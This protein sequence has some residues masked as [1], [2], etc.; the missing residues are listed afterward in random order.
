MVDK[1]KSL[2][3]TALFHFTKKIESLESILTCKYFEVSY[4][5]E[6][7]FSS[8]S[9]FVMGI[10]MVSFCDIRLSQLNEHTIK[11]GSFGLGMHK[12]WG[13]RMGLN[14]VLYMSKQCSLFKK[15][16]DRMLGLSQSVGKFVNEEGKSHPD[17]LRKVKNYRET[18]NPV[19]YMKNHQGTL[20]RVG[21]KPISNYRF[22]DEN[23]WRY[24]PGVM[25]TE[26]FVVSV[27]SE[28]RTRRD[29]KHW[30]SKFNDELK[31]KKLRLPFNINDIKYIIVEG[32]EE[33]DLVISILKKSFPEGEVDKL[34]SRLFCSKQIY[35]DL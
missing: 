29:H 1:L 15:Y 18:A 17:F 8:K 6:I 3:P 21:K 27:P 35:D 5:K 28:K 33:L 32:E 34:I 4:A 7:I 25:E 22:A 9:R 31:N 19:R 20:N 2:Y 13:E 26:H 12:S 23:E 24:V 14:P 11:Y 16:N 10:P 30:K